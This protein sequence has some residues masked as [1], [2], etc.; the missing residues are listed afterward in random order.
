MPKI[1]INITLDEEVHKLALSLKDKVYQPSLSS[2]LTYLIKKE[3][4]EQA[5]K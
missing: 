3:E 4:Q 1:R 5:K 2:F